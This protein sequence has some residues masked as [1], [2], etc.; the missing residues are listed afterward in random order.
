MSANPVVRIVDDD[1]EVRKSLEWLVDSVGISVET[2]ASAQEFLDAHMARDIERWSALLRRDGFEFL[3]N[4]NLRESSEEVIEARARSFS[5]S[6]L[7][8]DMGW[9]GARVRVLSSDAAVFRGYCHATIEMASGETRHWPKIF[10]TLL[11][12]RFD[13]GWKISSIHESYD[14]GSVVT[15]AAPGV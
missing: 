12:E 3:I 2:Y 6:W 10:F 9:D 1:P 7:D 15:T 4:G 13:D 11:Y 5:D 8:V 14:P